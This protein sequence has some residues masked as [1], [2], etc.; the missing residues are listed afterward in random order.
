MEQAEIDHLADAVLASL[1]EIKEENRKA[2][3][4]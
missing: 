2:L 3:V 1:R 4:S